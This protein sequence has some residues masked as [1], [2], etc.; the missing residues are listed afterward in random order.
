VPYFVFHGPFVPDELIQ[1]LEDDRVV[2][3]CGAGVSCGAGLPDFNGLVRSVYTE[4]GVT[5]PLEDDHKWLWPDRM[6]GEL[7]AR[8]SIETVRGAVA[9]ELNKEP[10]D[11]R[12][13]KALLRLGQLRRHQGLRLV[14]TNFDT[15]F[16]KAE[17]GLQRGF[18]LHSGP[19]L[20]IPCD[21]STASWRSVVYL[22]GRLESLGHK[23]DH[24]VMTSADFGRAYLTDGWA[25]R[26]VGRLFAD[27]SVLFVGYSLN[28]PVLRYMTDAFAAE[29]LSARRKTMRPQAYIFV[30]YQ[31]EEPAAK[32]KDDWH[33]RGLKPI[34]YNDKDN[35]R[36]LRETIEEWA[37]A[38]DNWLSNTY[39]LIRRLTGSS[40]QHLTPSDM[41]NMLWVLFRRHQDNGYGMRVFAEMNPLFPIDW[42]MVFEKYEADLEESYLD[43]VKQARHAGEREPKKPTLILRPLTVSQAYIRPPLSDTSKF[44]ADWLSKQLDQT[45]AIHWTADQAKRGKRLH[46]ELRQRIREN[47]VDSN[48]RLSASKWHFWRLVSSEASLMDMTEGS[49]CSLD[50]SLFPQETGS[51]DI[52]QA[53]MVALLRPYIR[54][55]PRFMQIKHAVELNDSDTDET[56]DLDERF[57]NLVDASIELAG[58]F[59]LKLL[60]EQLDELP[61]ANAR[62]SSIA[63]EM[64]S[65]LKLAMDLWRLVDK[66]DC[67]ND[68]SRI[69]Q[70]S[71]VPHT[72]NRHF[73]HWTILI[74][75]LWRAW[76]HIDQTDG[77]SSRCLVNRWY[78]FNYPIFR[79]LILAAVCQSSHWNNAEKLKILLDDQCRSLWSVALKKEALDLMVSI[80]VIL[81]E[82]ERST[83]IACIVAGPPMLDDVDYGHEVREQ[84]REWAD[85][86]IFVRLAL[87]E[88]CG[89]P[90]L[91][92]TGAE[93]L[94]LLRQSYPKWCIMKG[95][96]SHFSYWMD[97]E[98]VAIPSDP[99]SN[100]LEVLDHLALVD[101][102]RAE[103]SDFRG[104]FSDLSELLSQYPDRGI[105]VL[106]VLLKDHQPGDESIWRET[107]YGL[108]AH[109]E[110][111]GIAGPV[112]NILIDY[113]D[114]KVFDRELFWPAIDVLHTVSKQT[115]LPV[116]SEQFKKLWNE[117]VSSSLN[118]A[119][120]QVPLE[121]NWFQ[122]AIDEPLGR[123]TDALLNVIFSYDLKANQGFPEEFRGLFD[124]L[125]NDQTESG[126]I[127]RTI[128][129]SR[130]LYL[131]AIDPEW[132][133]LRILP[134]FDWN[135]SENE[136]LALWQGF[137][138]AVHINLELWEELSQF[139]YQAFTAP[140]LELL[141]NASR[142]FASLLMSVGIEMS[143]TL[144]PT[145]P[146]RQA[147]RAMEVCDRDAALNW[148][149]LMLVGL[150][151]NDESSPSEADQ[152]A[153]AA[154]VW[155]DRVYPWL[156]RIWPRDIELIV[157]ET[158]EKFALLAVAAGD[159]FPEAVDFVSHHM[160]KFEHW[161][162]LV[163][164]FLE[165][166]HPE[167]YPDFVL[168]LLGNIT[169]TMSI[170]RLQNLRHLLERIATV[171]P[172]LCN[173]N[174]T[175][176]LLDDELRKIAY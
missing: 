107:I 173:A 112:F 23:N 43:E 17:P 145:E 128:L 86:C 85:W 150:S 50:V 138:S 60:V 148:L 97:L 165:S 146:S 78:G 77:R 2:L 92:K 83:L 64:T 101:T 59:E 53:E 75:L 3:F 175:Y 8:F 73:Y 51:T 32:T 76:S 27:F 121:H 151:S 21:D 133:R 147:I 161:D 108:Q 22:H 137:S 144:V 115:Q 36:L 102:L 10:T 71:I 174:M 141:G 57:S 162:R 13:H 46:P 154:R 6:L 131:F 176:R 122:Y 168:R 63:D 37:R 99:N 19:L 163:H 35:H 26:F 120:E 114:G 69:H 171:D 44:L 142:I 109:M 34:F 87:I 14:T 123:I 125:T 117:L 56:S 42:L 172:V 90:L 79:R 55:S 89:Q 152:N 74:E 61:D 139:F 81:S 47:L 127:A 25:A 88:R 95:D 28:D 164:N 45:L 130:L 70:P 65:M 169:V 149:F 153:R 166:S 31:G 39:M 16:E 170:G 72:Q 9:S 1:D 111:P 29:A 66:A 113:Y 94:V 4:M 18:D 159:A 91:T 143:Q 30:P 11:T 156:N 110:K 116:T 126:R 93:K 41:D 48:F 40:P 68:L 129:V 15:Y 52:M 80:W 136:A 38:R 58:D 103:R 104:H 160:C 49:V 167:Q 135:R 119:V 20:P 54:I 124:P 62:L 82:E 5:P 140:R 67:D 106:S 12:L 105:E 84:K 132:V 158:S 134:Y 96:Q 100:E 155:R 157:P 98:N 24:L 7:E 118:E 33:H